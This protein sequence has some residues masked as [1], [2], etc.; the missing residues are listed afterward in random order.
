[1]GVVC[2]ALFTLHISNLIFSLMAL[3]GLEKRFCCAQPL[4]G[5]VIYDG[6]I[7]IWS[8]AVYFKSQSYNC[9]LEMGDVYFWLMGEI[10]FF[11]CL[12]AFVICYFF[13]KFCQDPKLALEAHQEEL[14]RKDTVLTEDRVNGVEGSG[15]VDQENGGIE[16]TTKATT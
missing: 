16:M 10:L 8:Q 9:N 12:T 7:L 15:K 13:R 1:M 4:L 3:C 14:D 2:W 5:L 11:Y 6:V